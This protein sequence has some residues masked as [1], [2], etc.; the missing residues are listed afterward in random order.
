MLGML[1]SC[2]PLRAKAHCVLSSSCP[3]HPS[4][5]QCP[6]LD[7]RHLGMRRTAPEASWK[8]G[9][10]YP[11]SDARNPQEQRQL[12]FRLGVQGRG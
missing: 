2:L 7:H 11:P 10:P 12:I 8:V 5:P 9:K 3:L 1:S 4:V 6:H